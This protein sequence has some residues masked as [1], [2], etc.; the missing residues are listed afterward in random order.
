MPPRLAQQH[1]FHRLKHQLEAREHPLAR[2]IDIDERGKQ[3]VVTTT[4][5]RLAHRI[6]D[7]VQHA[8]RGEMNVKFS[9]DEYRVR[10]HWSR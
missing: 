6:A 10:I 8:H 4:D 3:T 9:Q 2:I 1:E 5:L 7:A